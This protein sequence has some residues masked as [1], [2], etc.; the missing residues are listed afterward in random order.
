ME[1]T[2]NHKD[3]KNSLLLGLLIAIFLI[4]PEINLG[5][6]DK[7]PYIYPFTLIGLPLLCLLGMFVAKLLFE[8]VPALFQFIKFGLVG[9]GNTAVNFGVV[10]AFVYFSGIT[11]GPWV[12]LYSA[13]AFVVALCNSYYWNSQWSFKST[14]KRNFK[15][16]VIFA[17][18]TLF[19]L[20]INSLIVF[21][22]TKINPPFG[23][24][25]KL[26]INIANLIATLVVMFWNFFGFKL[27][28]FKDKS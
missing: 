3:Y 21:A 2:K 4:S 1:N 11:K 5:L 23:V 22:V 26:W 19:G 20:A 18:V 10:N 13:V 8:R 9:V 6:A 15:E 17:V 28:V 24:S 7:Y 12:I 25:G 16:F 14:G 27:F